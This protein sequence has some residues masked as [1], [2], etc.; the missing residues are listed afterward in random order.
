M[1]QLHGWQPYTGLGDWKRAHRRQCANSG[2]ASKAASG[3]GVDEDEDEDDVDAHASED[4]AAG[5]GLVE[6]EVAVK[7]Q[8]RKA[9]W[10][11]LAVAA[12]GLLG[13]S[14][15]GGG[16]GVDPHEKLQQL[17]TEQVSSMLKASLW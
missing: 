16:G 12:G 15:R 7:R 6:E 5:Q 10:R 8:R 9:W 11:R 3:L 4:Q 13:P 2:V 17:Q 1:L 14:R